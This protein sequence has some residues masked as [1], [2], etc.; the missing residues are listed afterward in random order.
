MMPFCSHNHCNRVSA[1]KLGQ[2]E[3][4]NNAAKT[5]INPRGVYPQTVYVCD[6]HYERIV[7]LL[8]MGH[9]LKEDN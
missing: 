7:K 1:V 9:L 4:P 2:I 6:R 5:D 8:G 3:V